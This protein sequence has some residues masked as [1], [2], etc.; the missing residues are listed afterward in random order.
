MG[1]HNGRQDRRSTHHQQQHHN[2]FAQQIPQNPRVNHRVPQQN[3][4]PNALYSVE[5][6]FA[7]RDISLLNEYTRVEERLNKTTSPMLKEKYADKL[8]ALERE[9]INRGYTVEK[10]PHTNACIFPKPIKSRATKLADELLRAHHKDWDRWSQS[11]DNYRA[12]HRLESAVEKQQPSLLNEKYP[13]NIIIFPLMPLLSEQ[14]KEILESVNQRI[15]QFFTEHSGQQE[16]LPP[17]PSVEF[18]KFKFE[19]DNLNPANFNP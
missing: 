15:A 13:T 9:I 8:H 19:D 16:N 2:F 10:H 12:K 7:H 5:N 18:V 3:R 11:L 6:G 1:K 4:E 17:E 14:R